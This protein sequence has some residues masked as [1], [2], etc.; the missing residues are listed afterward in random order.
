MCTLEGPHDSLAFAQINGTLK[1]HLHCA[2]SRSSLL[3]LDQQHSRP[4][5]S[6]LSSSRARMVSAKATAC[7][8]QAETHLCL[9]TSLVSCKD[10]G[11]IILLLSASK[12]GSG[13]RCSTDRAMH[14]TQS[15]TL[16]RGNRQ[17]RVAVRC[18][19]HFSVRSTSSKGD[20]QHQGFQGLRPA[21][22]AA[23]RAGRSVRLDTAHSVAMPVGECYD[24]ARR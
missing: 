7:R 5:V 10:Q 18:T 21:A 19:A 6:L 13:R 20:K 23:A 11:C 9:C 8:Q 24:Q 14:Q 1:E 17:A 3:A 4:M 2:A 16:R 15:A 22:A 12:S